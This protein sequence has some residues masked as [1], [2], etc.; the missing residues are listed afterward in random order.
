[1]IFCP[2]CFHE[3]FEHVNNIIH[4]AHRFGNHHKSPDVLPGPA[5]QCKRCKLCFVN[6]GTHLTVEPD[7]KP[8]A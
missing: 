4:A 2:R 8:A 3:D 5:L 6:H 1:M 7:Y